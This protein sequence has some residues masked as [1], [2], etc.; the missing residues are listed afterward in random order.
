MNHVN[1]KFGAQAVQR[2]CSLETNTLLAKVLNITEQKI[3][4]LLFAFLLQTDSKLG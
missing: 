2:R 3:N 4:H 1:I